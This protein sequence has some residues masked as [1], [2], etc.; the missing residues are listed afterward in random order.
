M[1]SDLSSLELHYLLK[2]IQP[3]VSGKLEQVYQIGKEE[4]ILQFHVPSQGKHILRIILGRMMYL[5]SAKGDV[6]D[7]PHG[8]CLYLRR[9]LKNARLR[10]LNQLGFERIVEFIFETKE[11]KFRLVIELFSKG[12]I[13][14][15]DEN[16]TIL[17]VMQQQEWKDRSLKPKQLYIYPEKEFN[18]LTI[19]E[20]DIK[21]LLHSS[22]KESVVKSLAIQLG[23]GGT[24]A[25]ELCILAKIDKNLKP[26]QLSDKEISSLH[27]AIAALRDK[28]ISPAIYSSVEG[29][30][31]DIVPF[32]LN[33]YKNLK[34]TKAESFNAALDTILTT[35]IEKKDLD[36]AEKHAKSKLDKI[37][38][39]IRQQT[40][41]IEGLEKSE[42]DNQRKGELIY[43]NYPLIEKAIE[44]IKEHR[45]TMSWKE[46]KEKFKG[47]KII[48]DVDTKT[49]EVTLEL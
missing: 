20:D 32:E 12:N 35:K 39:M 40:F 3:L 38:E 45:K 29:Q 7:K 36:S 14:L 31:K 2:E 49:G 42:A 47:H 1:K 6:P 15:C 10:E 4:L 30:L 24:Y 44:A 48:K 37:D 33:F 9:K 5:A 11:A 28:E 43:E 17:S 27:S 41:R 34:S 19:S 46:L 23:L 26:A 16:N 8:F 25:E 22:D 21:G 13:I 18:F